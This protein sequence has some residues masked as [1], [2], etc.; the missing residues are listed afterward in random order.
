ME[1]VL[2]GIRG[3]D[4]GVPIFAFLMVVSLLPPI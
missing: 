2:S 4:V 3:G 1:A